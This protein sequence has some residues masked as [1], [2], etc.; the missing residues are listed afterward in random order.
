MC[1]SSAIPEPCETSS[2][3]A[4]P[5]GSTAWKVWEVLPLEESEGL[6][7]IPFV[8]IVETTGSWRVCKT[9]SISTK[10]ALEERTGEKHTVN[11]YV[12]HRH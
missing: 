3:E 2:H 7:I 9:V 10:P 4:V 11:A 6:E 1:V 5:A 8:D 12:V